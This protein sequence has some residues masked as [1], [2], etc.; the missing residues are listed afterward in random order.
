MSKLIDQS[1]YELLKEFQSSPQNTFQNLN[2]IITNTATL[3]S[4]LKQFLSLGVLEKRKRMYKLTLKGRKLIEFLDEINQLIEIPK[5]EPNPFERIPNTHI[6]ELLE[7]YVGLLKK[8]FK[9]AL[10][11]VILFGSCAQGNWNEESDIDLLIIVREWAI[12]SWEKSRELIKVK[13]RLRKRETYKN[14]RRKGYH[15][16]ISHYPLSDTETKRLHP[17][18]YDI[19]LD[20]IIL[21]E[22]GQFGTHLL[23]HYQQELEQQK[24]KRITK[25]NKKRYWQIEKRT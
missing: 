14:L 18:F 13:K 20:G 8:H 4:R 17:V 23:K 15:F 5:K 2:A 21:Y 11:S 16:P 6:I 10:L 24:A 3:T 1:S 7:D 22:K 9:E 19:V 25:P 12:P